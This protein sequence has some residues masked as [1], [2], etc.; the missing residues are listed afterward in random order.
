MWTLTFNPLADQLNILGAR[1][2][3]AALADRIGR[4]H[5]KYPDNPINVIALSAG[6]GVA[7][8]AIENLPG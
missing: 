1:A 7:T 5:H 6:T 4:Y 2:R 3:A 8:W